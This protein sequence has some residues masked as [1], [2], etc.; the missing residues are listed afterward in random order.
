[1]AL[2]QLGTITRVAE[3][4]H[5]SPAAIHKQLKTLEEGLGVSLY[6]KNGRRLQLTQATAVLLPYLNEMLAQCDSALSALEE[7]RGNKRGLVR[8]GAGPTI[9]SYILPSMLKKFRTA[10]SGVELLIQTGNTQVLLENL[11]KGEI[12]LALLVSCDLIE[13]E[14]FSVEAHWDFE[15]VL[16]SHQRQMSRRPKLADLRNSRFIL[17]PTGS[18]MQQPIDRYFAAHGFEPNVIMRFD[19]AEAIKAMIRT[20]LGIS[21]LPMWIVDKDLKS[22][23]LTLLRQQEPTL[24]S[25]IALISRRSSYV[26]HP[27]RA[28]IAQARQIDWKNPRLVAEHT[29][30]AQS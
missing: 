24:R 25:K 28:F 17:F 10:H 22:R 23:R 11:G 16:V 13:A 14:R 7:W 29:R 6:E 3:H 19:N 12:D 5:L 8:I 21:M 1:M 9:S 27:V 18:R 20:G 15:L 2:S 4:L 26:A 30:A